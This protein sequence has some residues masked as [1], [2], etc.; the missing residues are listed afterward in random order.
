MNTWMPSSLF[1][2]EPKPA[3]APPHRVVGRIP[4][5]WCQREDVDAKMN[6]IEKG[7]KRPACI[8]ATGYGKGAMIAEMAGRLRENGKIVVL[9]DRSHLVHQIADEIDY[10]LGTTC[11]RVAD[12]EYEGLNRQIIVSTV[13]AMYTPDRSGTPLYAYSQ[14]K[15]VAAVIG[16]EA[17]KLFADCFRAVPMHFV[18]QCN[19]IVSLFTATPIASN[20]AAWSSF[21]DWTPAAEGPCMRTAGWCIRNGYLVPPLQAYV[22]SQ[23]DL[24]KIHDRVGSDDTDN[25]DAGDELA[26]LLI[27]LLKQKGEREAA[28]FMAGAAE[29]IGDR[30]AIIFTPA[31]VET[32]K[33][34]ASWLSATGRMHCE[35]VWGNRVDKAKVLDR[36]KDGEFQALTSVNLLCE[37]YND[38]R[39][40]AVF[41]CRLLNNW[42]IIQQM[43]GRG[44]R[45]LR[46]TAALL[47]QYDTPEGAEQRRAIIAASAKPNA[48]I[49]DLVGLDG[50]VLRASAIDVLYDGES[51][52]VKGE[53]AERAMHRQM[54]RKADDERPESDEAELEAAK[55]QL[56]AKQNQQLAELARRR[57]M[58]GDVPADVQ[59]SYGNHAPLS[60]PSAPSTTAAAT[61]GEKARFV[62]FALKYDPERAKAIADSKPRH[63][64]RGMIA[65]FQRELAKQ[66]R[67]P[68]WARARRAYPDFARQGAA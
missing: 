26:G 30:R 43:V 17:H 44:L 63:V 25:E 61:V 14:F 58:A 2:V 9:I 51:E 67:G 3:A 24:S 11:G 56:Q 27:D 20:G 50:K 19:A 65:S 33:L 55:Q 53:L 37:G 47:N 39:V 60:M 8:G 10:H 5:R 29:V 21:V 1:D 31:R 54:Q 66:H 46:E 36:H 6:A 59:V 62:A 23:L 41:I 40:S 18:D 12:S 28:A 48:L 64:L 49:A 15:K 7:A 34:M 42:R 4:L 32:T 22:R 35:P 45:P 13:Q 68:D 16:D 52:D 38:P 57:A